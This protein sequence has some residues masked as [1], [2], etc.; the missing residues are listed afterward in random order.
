MLN[1]ILEIFQQFGLRRA[2]PAENR[3]H[4]AFPEATVDD[5]ARWRFF[6]EGVEAFALAIAKRVA[7]RGLD[8][9]SAMWELSQHFPDLTSKRLGDTYG[10]ALYFAAQ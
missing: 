9:K 10:Q 4:E 1:E 2:I 3:W 5:F 8:E 6:C 7:N